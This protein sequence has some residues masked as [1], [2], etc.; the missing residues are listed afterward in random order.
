[1]VGGI[2]G[3]VLQGQLTSGVQ[4]DSVLLGGL[5]DTDALQEAFLISAVI[6]VISGQTGDEALAGV[7]LDLR[8]LAW[9]MTNIT[10]TMLLNLQYQ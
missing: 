4:G 8:A 10:V 9:G 3:A 2:G 1:M 7:V 5:V 6:I